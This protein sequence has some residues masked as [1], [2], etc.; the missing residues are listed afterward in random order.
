M[1]KKISEKVRDELLRIHS[2]ER[3]DLKCILTKRLYKEAKKTVKSI[4]K[5]IERAEQDVVCAKDACEK[6]KTER[7]K[8]LK[9][10][11]LYGVVF[12]NNNRYNTCELDET[13]PDIIAFNAEST[14]L[15]KEI[16]L[17]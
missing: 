9:E 16:L 12:E 11:M 4:E 10:K 15:R 2:T 14:K 7:D 13:H 8:I 6:V 1:S 3:S 5:K 17:L